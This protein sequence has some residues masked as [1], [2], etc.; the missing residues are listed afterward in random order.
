MSLTPSPTICPTRQ[1]SRV[2]QSRNFPSRTSRSGLVHSWR[3]SCGTPAITRCFQH[4]CTVAHISALSSLLTRK[5]NKMHIQ[6]RKNDAI[7]SIVIAQPPPVTSGNNRPPAKPNSSSACNYDLPLSYNFFHQTFYHSLPYSPCISSLCSLA[8]LTFR[9]LLESLSSLYPSSLAV[10]LG[11][12][13][14]TREC[15][16][17]FFLLYY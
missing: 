17:C 15:T 2:L 5:T 16:C 14:H 12:N 11:N 1:K 7:D 10:S 8:P 4:S 9:T 3:G 13:T 6:S